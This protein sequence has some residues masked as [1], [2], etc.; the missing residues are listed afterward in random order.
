MAKP[1]P[2]PMSLASRERGHP[3]P[4]R[5]VRPTDALKV[6]FNRRSSNARVLRY[7]A[8][9]TA[10]PSRV[11]GIGADARLCA[12]VAWATESCGGPPPFGVEPE[13][14]VKA[15]AF[16]WGALGHGNATVEAAEPVRYGGHWGSARRRGRRAFDDVRLEGGARGRYPR[17][18]RE[19]EPV[20]G[21]DRY[22]DGRLGSARP[23]YGRGSRRG[24]PQRG[25]RH[26][27]RAGPVDRTGFGGTVSQVPAGL[28]RW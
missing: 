5:P 18:A 15:G 7:L 1:H 23:K 17:A 27:R 19:P 21:S 4:D 2:R 16:A 26:A 24:R 22:K 3:K 20:R 10:E 25:D 8:K 11:N 13:L 14:V 6:I 28:M 9:V 12:W